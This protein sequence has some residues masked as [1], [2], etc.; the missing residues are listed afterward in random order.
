M[1]D[2]SGNP[3]L[4]WSL[5]GHYDDCNDDN[6]T[7]DDDV[8]NHDYDNDDDNDETLMNVV[9]PNFYGTSWSDVMMIAA[10]QM[11]P[12]LPLI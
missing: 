5:V 3:K 1:S 12:F 9:I 4:L 6:T 7:D 10:Q 8:N 2:E 11:T